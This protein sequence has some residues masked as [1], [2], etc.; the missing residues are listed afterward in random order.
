MLDSDNDGIP[1]VVEIQWGSNPNAYDS[2]QNG[3]GDGVEYFLYG[4]PCG[5]IPAGQLGKGG[6][7]TTAGALN[8]Y[9]GVPGCGNPG[10]YPNTYPDTDADYLNDCEEGLIGTSRTDFDSNQDWVPDQLEW[11]YSISYLF[12]Q[13]SLSA[14]PTNDGVSNYQKLKELYPINTPITKIQTG[15]LPLS[16]TLTQSSTTSTQTCYNVNVQSIATMSPSDVIRVY[17][18]ETQG[19]NGN[20]RHM[21]VLKN[22]TKMTNGSLTINDGDLTP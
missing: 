15:V 10:A 20:L 3:L 12:G 1:D 14:N 7:C 8:S 16:Y 2:D 22:V 6:T 21:R 13:N 18:M 11:L 4:S 19:S 5:S 17:V 9:L